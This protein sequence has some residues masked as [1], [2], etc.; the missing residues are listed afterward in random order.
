MKDVLI[1]AIIILVLDITYLNIT[2]RSYNNLVRKV[3]GSDIKMNYVGAAM[4]YGLIMVSQ[5]YFI[6]KKNAT[7][8]EAGLLGL[9]IYGIFNTTNIAILDK[10]GW[11]IAIM[12][13][14]W[15]ATAYMATTY[16]Y[17]KIMN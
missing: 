10:W 11:Q 4:A 1:L 13:T 2:S 3:Q 12:D 9:C 17:R 14:V 8:W 6:T 5:Y 15:G 16:I 7:I